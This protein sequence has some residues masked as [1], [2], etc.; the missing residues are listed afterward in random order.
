M[1]KA[2]S[3]YVIDPVDGL[4]ARV[5]REWARRKHHYL[6]RYA[7]IFATGMKKFPRRAYL[8]LFAGPGRCFEKETGE[9]YDG[10]PLIG[11]R[12]NFTDHIYVELEDKAAAALDARC[13]PWKRERYV[14]V[15]P[16][17]CNAK[18]DEVIGHLPR[19]G[20]TFAFIDPTNWQISFDTIRR[21]TATRR[22]DLLVSFFGPSMKRVAALDQPRVDAFFGTKA[23]QTDPRFLGPD[24]RPTLS[25]LLA[26]YREQLAGIGYLNQIS[27][28]EIEVKNSKNVPMYLMAFFSKH[29]LGYTFW[30]RIT[31]EDEKGQIALDW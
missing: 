17:D 12:R 2:P 26:C 15:I 27:A 29:P 14:T 31:T 1:T 30:D 6:E 10:S 4:P 16:G 7:D 11:L 9:T 13:S 22:V 25:G 28:R 18:I 5:V 3:E 8:D 20:I 24:H 23:W 21:L 19:F